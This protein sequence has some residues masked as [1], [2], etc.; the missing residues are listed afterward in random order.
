M[1]TGGRVQRLG[2]RLGSALVKRPL[3]VVLARLVVA[4]LLNLLMPQLETVVARDATPFV[5]RDAPVQ[6]FRSLLAPD[7]RAHRT[8]CRRDTKWR[9]VIHC[10]KP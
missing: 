5:P 6:A 9:Y 3:P 8:V 7:R 10:R 4:G 2:A 1:A